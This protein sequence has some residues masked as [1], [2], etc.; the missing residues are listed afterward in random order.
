MHE[1]YLRTL[2]LRYSILEKSV[3][4]I[5]G[6]GLREIQRMTGLSS[7]LREEILSALRE[8]EAHKL[9][10]SSFARG[11]CACPPVARQYGSEQAFLYELSLMA[12]EVDPGFLIV[13]GNPSRSS[14]ET[15]CGREYLR[16]RRDRVPLLALDLCE[17]AWFLDFGF[18]RDEYIRR[19]LGHFNL[20]KITDFFRERENN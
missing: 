20:G 2:S 10:F 14:V 19:A 18:R 15:E 5:E 13:Y 12:R 8:R 6:K 11:G 7:T 3:P 4:A 9:Y 17:H 1:E 16:F